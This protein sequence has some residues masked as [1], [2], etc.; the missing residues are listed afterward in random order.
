MQTWD[1]VKVFWNHL[2]NGEV[3]RENDNMDVKIM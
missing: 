3:G 1:F 2:Q